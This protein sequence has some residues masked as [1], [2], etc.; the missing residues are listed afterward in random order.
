M[1]PIR[2]FMGELHPRQGKTFFVGAHGIIASIIS[3][4]GTMIGPKRSDLIFVKTME[5]VP[6]RLAQ[7]AA[8]RQQ[9]EDKK[10][11]RPAA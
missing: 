11:S 2:K 10:N 3:V 6:P 9:E 4:L 8:M 5:E 7:I 1:T